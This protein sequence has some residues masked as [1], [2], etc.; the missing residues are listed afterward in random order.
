M[1]VAALPQKKGRRDMSLFECKK[2]QLALAAVELPN[3]Q[4]S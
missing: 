3:V 2:L 4:S 1:D